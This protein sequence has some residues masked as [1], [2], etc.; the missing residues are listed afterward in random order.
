MERER[1]FITSSDGGS[2]FCELLS[3]IGVAPGCVGKRGLAVSED[4]RG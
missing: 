1:D 4:G 3:R 2:R